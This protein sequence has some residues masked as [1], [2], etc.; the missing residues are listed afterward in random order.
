MS[1]LRS[2]LDKILT[3]DYFNGLDIGILQASDIKRVPEQIGESWENRSQCD[4]F[5]HIT[6]LSTDADISEIKKIELTNE[7]DGTT[8]III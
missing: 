5:F 1:T 8:T 2:S 4:F 6:V 7:I 3:Q